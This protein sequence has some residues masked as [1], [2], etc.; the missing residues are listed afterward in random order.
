MAM[1]ENYE[2]QAKLLLTRFVDKA[3]DRNKK[4]KTML[5]FFD[6]TV[7]IQRCFREM[8]LKQLYK[9]SVLID[10]VEDFIKK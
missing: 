10:I 3:C 4:L 7:K 6:G 1:L 8:K 9:S 2:K 5:T